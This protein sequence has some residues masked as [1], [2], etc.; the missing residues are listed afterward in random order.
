M[1][2][3]LAPRSTKIYTVRIYAN[4]GG[5]T[6]KKIMPPGK[7]QYV[8]CLFCSFLFFLKTRS[9]S[10]FLC[11]IWLKMCPQKRTK[12]IMIFV[13]FDLFVLICSFLIFLPDFLNKM[14]SNGEQKRTKQIMPPGKSQD[15]FV[16]FVVGLPPNIYIFRLLLLL[17]F[18]AHE[19]SKLTLII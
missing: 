12:K 15:V 3:C 19:Q 4:M 17:S 10:T 7:T 18:H 11:R 2:R 1:L 5:P 9:K 13:F 14:S 8:L 16:F 6:T